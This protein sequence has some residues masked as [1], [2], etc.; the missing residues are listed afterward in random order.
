MLLLFCWPAWTLE[1]TPLLRASLSQERT[2]T[3]DLDRSHV[4]GC[5][6][7]SSSGVQ[8]TIAQPYIKPNTACCRPGVVDT[9][10]LLDCD[11]FHGLRVEAEASPQA[12]M[13][14]VCRALSYVCTSA[15]SCDP[16]PLQ[17]FAC[18]VGQKPSKAPFYM[19]DTAEVAGLLSRLAEQHPAPQAAPATLTSSSSLRSLQQ[20]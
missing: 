7:L 20:R 11:P 13:L 3:E 14:R 15:Q 18:T 9:I 5:P 10:L 12:T 2:P 4:A 6:P 8:S 1:E 19:N 17:V 16:S